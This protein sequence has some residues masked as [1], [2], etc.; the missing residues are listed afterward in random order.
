M[1]AELSCLVHVHS[2]YSDGTATVAELVEAAAAAG[3]QALLLTDHDSLQAARDGWAGWHDGVLVIVGHEISTRRGHLLAFGT[4]TEIP[5][6]GRSERELCAAVRGAGGFGIAAHPFSEG[7][8][9]S[10]RVGRPHPWA[11]LDAPGCIGLEL[12]SLATDEAEAWRSPRAAWR[13]LRHPERYIDGPPE[14]HLRAWDALCAH[15]RVVAVGGLD[16]HQPGVR[17]RGRVRSIMP[18]SRWFGLLRTQVL[19][20]GPPSRDGAAA[21]AQVLGAV[22]AGRC[23]LA[24]VDLGAPTSFAFAGSRPGERVRMGEQARSGDWRLEA[25]SPLPARLRLLR[26]G[27]VVATADGTRI[28][29]AAHAPGAYRV[30][31]L[32]PAHGRLRRW[33]V[34]NPVYLRP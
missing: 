19:L 29:H 3:A 21:C 31:A 1:A 5:H 33:I 11:A 15:R 13:T 26:D 23:Q 22:H 14:P 24:R 2:T 25:A 9:M 4:G 10:R 34:T 7:S 12:W 8:R 32:R 6:R 17:V 18:H 30:E 20:D 16:A 27:R 28:S